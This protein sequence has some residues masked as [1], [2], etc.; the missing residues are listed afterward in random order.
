MINYNI[1]RMIFPNFSEKSNF[2]H[3]KK[4]SYLVVKSCQ[5]MAEYLK[6]T[7]YKIQ[8][9]NKFQNTMSEITN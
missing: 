5:E 4:S 2:S 8:I 9:T 7:K 1:I 6:I 3:M